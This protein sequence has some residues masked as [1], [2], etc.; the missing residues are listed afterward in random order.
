M[1]ASTLQIVEHVLTSTAAGQVQFLPATATLV[2]GRWVAV[3]SYSVDGLA[4]SPDIQVQIFTADLVPV[5]SPLVANTGVAGFQGEARVAALSDGG[6]VVAWT[7]Y[8][9][10][11][12]DASGQSVRAQ[13]FNASGSLRGTELLLNTTTLGDQSSASLTALAGG[14][15]MAAWVDTSATG[16]DTDLSAVRAQVF[17]A[18]GSKLGAELLVNSSTAMSQF[19][20]QLITLG[21]GRLVATWTSGSAVAPDTLGFAVHGQLMLPNGNK[22]GS[23]FVLNT[24]TAGHQ[25]LSCLTALP[26]GGFVAVWSDAS[27]PGM[28]ALRG[29]VFGADGAKVGDEFVGVAAGARWYSAVQALDDGRFVLAWTDASSAD[30]LKVTV[31]EADGSR[32]LDTLTLGLAPNALLQPPSL[33]VLAGDR[34]LVSYDGIAIGQPAGSPNEVLTQLIDLT[35]TP[36]LS[37]GTAQADT[38]NGTVWSDSMSGG[39]GNDTLYGGAQNDRLSGQAGHDWLLGGA[40]RDSLLGGLGN[41]VLHGDDGDDLLVAQVG[42][43]RLWGEAGQDILDGGSGEDLVSGGVGNDSLLGG[44]GDDLLLG[45]VGFDTLLGGSGQDVLD[46]G[47]GDDWLHGDEGNDV[48]FGSVGRD[49]LEGGAGIDVFAFSTL[50]EAGVGARRDTIVDFESGEDF[51]YLAQMDAIAAT[52]EV[53]D[54]WAFIHS[55]AFSGH[56]GELRY[57]QV[58]GLL[59]GDV[60]GDTVADFQVLLLGNPPLQSSDLLLLA[61]S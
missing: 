13:V 54:V 15:F 35:V 55:S 42:N 38:L 50:A 25:M 20:P 43:D 28:Q 1:A 12:A 46:G 44:D 40:G 23:E 18:D 59:Q 29:Q 47:A 37:T 22:V 14:G 32:V 57:Q 11:G 33:T 58:T 39:L 31:F 21:D 16:V 30:L 8:I 53:L 51:I 60:N 27:Q 3:W 56:A 10:S 17:A 5:G 36:N 6:F 4:Q 26:S 19:A 24:A 34:L 2:D 9:A 41:D 45:N 52:P 49:M 61:V 48:L 7:S